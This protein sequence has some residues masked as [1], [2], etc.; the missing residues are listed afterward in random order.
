[1]SQPRHQRASANNRFLFGAPYYP[2]HWEPHERVSDIER[3]RSA[4]V[5]V[6]RMTEFAWD[7]IEPRE[8]QFDFDLFDTTISELGQAGIQTIL[9]TPTATPPAW[10][11][12]G[13]PGWMRVTIEG[14]AMSH[15]SRQH[16]CT[17]NEEFRSHSRR[18]TRKMAE[19]FT[20]SPH[21]IGW[22]TDN[23]LFCHLSQCICTSCAQSF[24]QWLQQRYHSIEKLNESWGSSFWALSFDDF[25]QIQLEAL[26]RRPTHFNPSMYLDYR[27]F[28]SEQ[29]TAFQREQVEILRD[30][31]PSWWVT[32]NGLFWNLDYWPF[33]SDLDFLSVDIYPQYRMSTPVESYHW[34]QLAER[35]RAASGSFL[36]LEQQCGPGAQGEYMHDNPRPGQ[37]RLWAYQAISHGADG[38][39]HFRW[40]TCKFGAEMYWNGVLDQDNIP[41]R[42]YDE[43]RNEGEELAR[44][45]S[46]IVGTTRLVEAAILWEEEQEM[47]HGG[48]G[49]GLPSPDDQKKELC[50][51]LGKRH[52]PF[53]IVDLHDA[54][55][56]VSLAIMPS[57]MVIDEPRAQK[58]KAFVS[59]GGILVA[60]ARTA[61]RSPQN[62]VLTQT[63]PG[64]LQDLFGVQIVEFGKM[65][66]PVVGIEQGEHQPT[67][68]PS[69]EILSLGS[70]KS[71]ATWSGSFDGGPHSAPGLPAISVNTFGQGTAIYVGTHIT[72]EN[73]GSI[74]QSIL[75]QTDVKPLGVADDAVE[76][77]CRYDSATKLY[78]VLNHYPTPRM[79]G[80][81][82][83]GTDLLSGE[84]SSGTLEI[85]GYG[86]RVIKVS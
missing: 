15:G 25:S 81:L 17:N 76:I 22:Q 30:V 45:G 51:E 29:V 19:H 37:M 10:L 82:P 57:F 86:V 39:L 54:L 61:T 56:G 3:M 6:I 72:G 62:Q 4:G 31:N 77:G 78:F 26:A 2:E 18:I 79:V 67:Q 23:E 27:R 32:H 49:L 16:C 84:R 74:L 34:A 43:F 12:E 73:V 83:T 44:I 50:R 8:N 85:E 5:N 58:L 36:V 69:Y 35:C 52:L 9:C 53:G 60:T 75:S 21:V 46:E 41:R 38:I 71:L 42:R 14:T 33:A 63:P 59:N 47:A 20:D 7:R 80:Q 70:A 1:M 13:H 40:R 68:C 28:I 24:H 48:L 66:A 64:F 65:N 55:D 11:T